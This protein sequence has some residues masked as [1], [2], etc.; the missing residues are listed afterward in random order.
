MVYRVL[1]SPNSMWVSHSCC[2]AI[3]FSLYV[4]DFI[5]VTLIELCGFLHMSHLIPRVTS[6]VLFYF[7]SLIVPSSYH[8]SYP[9]LHVNH[10]CLVNCPILDWSQL[11]PSSLLNCTLHFKYLRTAKQSGFYV[12]HLRED[13]SIEQSIVTLK[14]QDC[15]ALVKLLC[16]VSRTTVPRWRQCFSTAPLGV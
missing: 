6:S 5:A 10:L 2:R 1:D 15:I 3:F 13:Q 11:C 9:P 12:I 4:Q 14:R 7:R 8:T 16:R